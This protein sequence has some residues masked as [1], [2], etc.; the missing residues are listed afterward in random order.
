MILCSKNATISNSE[1][2]IPVEDPYNDDPQAM[3]PTDERCQSH[4]QRRPPVRYGINEAIE[5]ESIEAALRW[6]K[7]ESEK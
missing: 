7:R 5:L 6:S 3:E 2:K 1:K 4:R